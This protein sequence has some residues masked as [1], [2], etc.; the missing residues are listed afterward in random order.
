MNEIEKYL[1]KQT[2]IIGDVN[3]GKTL[4]T[5]RM[6]QLFINA[7]YR[8]NITVLDLSPGPVQGIGGKMRNPEINS[9]LYLTADIF[10]PRL[11]GK[12][13][14]HTRMLTQKNV[15]IIEE[16]FDQV[17]KHGKDILFVNDA[18]LYLQ[19]GSMECFEDILATATTL[20]INSY[21]GEHFKDSDLTRREKQLA[22]DL[23]STCDHVIRM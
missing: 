18:S 5:C 14:T 23:M 4:E 17:M 7:G 19:A 8:E 9:V 15:R 12:S 13:E 1:K 3:S 10:A 22:E 16:L 2:L 11:S 6:L 21:Y 20:V